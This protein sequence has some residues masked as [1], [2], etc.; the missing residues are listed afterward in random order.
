[1]SNETGTSHEKA[2]IVTVGVFV[3][4]ERYTDY[5][6]TEHGRFEGG[7]TM[8]W[9]GISYDGATE[10]QVLHGNVTVVIY[11]DIALKHFVRLLGCTRKFHAD[12]WRV[13]V[14]F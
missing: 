11:R 13:V 7:S 2:H 4:P 12:G 9:G 1:M 8:A 10:L 6:I 5:C 3:E 14:F